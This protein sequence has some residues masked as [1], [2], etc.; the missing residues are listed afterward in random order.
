M[1]LKKN[2]TVPIAMTSGG[3]IMVSGFAA[4]KT[5]EYWQMMLTILPT[6]RINI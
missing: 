4:Y 2:A 5:I 6:R 3:E 1:A